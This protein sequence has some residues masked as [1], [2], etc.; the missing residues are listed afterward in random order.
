MSLNTYKI[1]GGDGQEYGPATLEQLQNWIK[2][3]RVSAQTQVRRSD[4]NVWVPASNVAELGT[5]PS[6]LPSAQL[7]AAAPELFSPDP[8]R[9]GLAARVKSGSGWFFWIAALSVVNSI[10]ALSKAS[11]VFIVGL[12]VTQIIDSFAFRGGSN[13]VAVAAALDLVAAGIFVGFGVF[14]RKG[15]TWSFL[16][17]MVLY[18]LDG[19]IFLLARDWLAF[20]FHIFALYCIFNGFRALR[21]L[22]QTGR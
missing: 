3:G 14:A 1:M 6:A 12:G 8:V 15:H 19:L 2:E 7:Q 22:R 16:V 21:Q 20:G 17:G 13:G 4:Q 11:F 5:V 18:A 10:A 9:F